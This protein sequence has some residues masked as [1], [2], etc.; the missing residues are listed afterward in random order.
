MPSADWI[1]PQAY[2]RTVGAWV[3]ISLQRSRRCTGKLSQPWMYLPDHWTVLTSPTPHPQLP[4]LIGRAERAANTKGFERSSQFSCCCRDVGSRWS[5]GLVFT[6]Q[7]QDSLQHRSINASYWDKDYVCRH[8][9]HVVQSKNTFS[10]HVIKTSI[11]ALWHVFIMT[12]W[13]DQVHQSDTLIFSAA[14]IHLGFFFILWSEK[15]QF[16]REVFKCKAAAAK[17]TV[18]F[19]FPVWR[20]TFLCLWFSLNRGDVNVTNVRVCSTSCAEPLHSFF[21]LHD[22]IKHLINKLLR[23]FVELYPPGDT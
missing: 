12:S 14:W 15:Y 4:T 3:Q 5:D 20:Q 18:A 1:L 6:I 21:T 10:Q 13:R 9:L 11:F 23:M 16:F 7:L 22:C 8:L 2:V 17:T 19:D